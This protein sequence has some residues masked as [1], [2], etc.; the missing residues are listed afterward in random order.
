MVAAAINSIPR[1]PTDLVARYG[2]EEFVVLLPGSEAAGAQTVADM[3]RQAVH[4]LEVP[5][6]L[7]PSQKV[8]VSMGLASL[9]PAR[10]ADA[11]ELIAAADRALYQAK[12]NGRDRVEVAVEEAGVS[13]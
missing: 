1:R 5:H 6:A 2:G 3:L 11:A 4:A 8:T 9:V 13:R 7:S 12:R 10:G